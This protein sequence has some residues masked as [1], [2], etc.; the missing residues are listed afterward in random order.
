MIIFFVGLFLISSVVSIKICHVFL[1]FY[2]ISAY[3]NLL[4]N[5]CSFTWFFPQNPQPSNYDK[6]LTIL[7]FSGDIEYNRFCV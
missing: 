6:K 4:H 5:P 3:K 1:I 2:I 7:D